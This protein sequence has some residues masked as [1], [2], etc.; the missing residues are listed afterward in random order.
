MC[1]RTGIRRLYCKGGPVALALTVAA[2]AFGQVA[3]TEETTVWV[4]GSPTASFAS[5]TTPEA[6]LGEVLD[7]ASLLDEL[8]SV[9]VR[10][11]GAEGSYGTLSVRG[12]AST[13]VAVFVGGIPITGGADPT[14]DA[15]ALPLWPGAVV[16][17]YRGFAPAALGATGY[18]GGVVTIDPPA[19]AADPRT[20][21]WLAAGSFGTLKLRVGDTR[22]VDGWTLSTGLAA[23]RTDGDFPY[24]APDPRTQRTEERVRT[25]AAHAGVSFVER[26]ALQRPWGNV[27]VLLLLDT[28]KRGLSG[29]TSHPTE[30]AELSTSRL[31]LGAELTRKVSAKTGIYGR[32][33]GR[34]ELARYTDPRGELGVVRR[35]ADGGDTIT[36]L[37][38]AF[39]WRGRPLD[40]LRLDLFVDGRA[41]R[42][43]PE[44]A[45]PV[46][47]GG[48]ARR[49]A[50]GVGVD[51]QLLLPRGLELAAAARVD[52]RRDD[53]GLG[54]PRDALSGSAHAGL[55]FVV[56][57]G[58]TL[59]THGGLLERPPSFVELYGDRG[60]LLGDPN[61]RP[62]RAL[63]IDAGLRG[64]HAFSGVGVGYEL[65]GFATRAADLITFEELGEGTLV[66]RNVESATLVGLEVVLGLST[67]SAR[68]TL[69]YTWLHTEN[70]G[71]APLTE[72]RPLPGR[73]VHDLA[74]DAAY[75]LGPV[76]L[77][78]GVDAI[79]GTTA[80]TAGRIE[81]PARFLHGAGVGVTV[82][83]LRVGLSV[84][85]LFDVRVL[86][87]PS[88]LGAR[89]V[90]VPVSDFLD[91]P[92]PGR[93]V[94]VTARTE[95]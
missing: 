52:G 5:K 4:H 29:T 94:W 1:R 47:R 7:A 46:T 6:A 71:A 53:A 93:T 92:L 11:L 31:A 56:N 65:V 50:V 8:P 32:F 25:N 35:P 2:P 33:Y 79:A 19:N 10:R 80:D 37:G 34:H 88:A 78:Y 85:N 81:L 26:A 30:A 69:S 20:S 87:R 73:P 76:D 51:A 12:S 22:G 21:T 60:G 16:R 23:S 82:A 14:V 83:P 86:H 90:A 95:L 48:E 58:L 3:S 41:E 42:F 39:G 61:L 9:H 36:S 72:G 89:P 49:D 44:G 54:E 75:F 18:L 27:S 70:T 91:F 62:E 59:A 43:A 66:A 40:A 13:E 77:H 67:R 74:Y 64:G 68:T 24:E 55:S 15:G 84:E 57:E 63:A 38:G 17:V 28:A 45:S